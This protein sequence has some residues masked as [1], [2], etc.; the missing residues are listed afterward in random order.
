MKPAGVFFN[1]QKAYVKNRAFRQTAEDYSKKQADCSIHYFWYYR[2]K[3]VWNNLGFFAVNIL[4]DWKAGR[5]FSCKIINHLLDFL[6]FSQPCGILGWYIQSEPVELMSF[7]TLLL[8]TLTITEAIIFLT[9]FI[10]SHLCTAFANALSIKFPTV[11]RLK[12]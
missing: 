6:Y 9:F 5:N 3:T 7:F 11:Y 10:F 2:E 8:A 1:K 4:P 12:Q